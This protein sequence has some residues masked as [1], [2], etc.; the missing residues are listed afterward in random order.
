MH[1]GYSVLLLSLLGVKGS[2]VALCG[3]SNYVYSDDSVASQAEMCLLETVNYEVIFK[4]LT[5][6]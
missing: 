5:L 3:V 6:L 1:Y 4:D 2:L